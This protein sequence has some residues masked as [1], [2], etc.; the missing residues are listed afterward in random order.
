MSEYSFNNY[1]D[2]QAA[3]D[4]EYL[5]W[6]GEDKQGG[7]IDINRSNFAQTEEGTQAREWWSN[8]QSSSPTPSSYTPPPSPPSP[9]PILPNFRPMTSNFAIKQAPIDTVV[10]DDTTFPPAMLE[11]LMYEDI[12][13]IELANMSRSDLIDGQDVSY[14]PIK[15]LSSLRRRF[16]PN[17]IISSSTSSGNNFSKFSIDLISRGMNVPYLDYDGN[18]VIEIDE[19]HENEVIDVE[20]ASSGTINTVNI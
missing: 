7:H 3:L 8:Q 5:A 11:D 4:R 12:G 2:V 10:F 13:G 16:N 14:T 20:I 1:S 18:L 15:N 6:L 9:S 17:N 19:V